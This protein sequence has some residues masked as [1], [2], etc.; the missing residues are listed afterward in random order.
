MSTQNRTRRRRAQKS[1]LMTDRL[2]GPQTDNS[3]DDEP[4]KPKRVLAPKDTITTQYHIHAKAPPTTFTFSFS[5]SGP[6][7]TV[8]P[9][10]DLFDTSHLYDQPAPAPAAYDA[11]RDSLDTLPMDAQYED[12]ELPDMQGLRL[13]E[14]NQNLPALLATGP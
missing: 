7:T 1:T 4:P 5:S 12:E 13:E 3:V 11:T 8:E 6:S 9:Q 10:A 2:H 14:V